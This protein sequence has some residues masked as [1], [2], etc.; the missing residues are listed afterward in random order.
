VSRQD[1][2]STVELRPYHI[3]CF[4]TPAHITPI[5]ARSRDLTKSPAQLG[6]YG[7]VAGW[8]V[9]PSR[10]RFIR[11]GSSKPSSSSLKATVSHSRLRRGSGNTKWV[12]STPRPLLLPYLTLVSTL[13]LHLHL[14][15]PTVHRCPFEGKYHLHFSDQHWDKREQS[16]AGYLAQLDGWMDTEDLS[17]VS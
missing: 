11:Y 5:A 14:H 8:S 17:D 9:R 6:C 3:P 12:W 4:P 7:V 16:R 15:L 13:H 1:H 10:L 2:L